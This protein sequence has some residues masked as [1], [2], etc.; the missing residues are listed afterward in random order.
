MEATI[1]TEHVFIEIGLQVL[2]LNAP[3]M[4]PEYPCLEVRKHLVN[5]RKVFFRV[6][7]IAVHYHRIML[8]SQARQFIVAGATIAKNR[9]WGYVLFNELGKYGA[10][11]VGNN[12]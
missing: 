10:A 6:S 11:T 7:G 2:H 1:K 12:L 5:H 8:V 3:V 4:R 9:R